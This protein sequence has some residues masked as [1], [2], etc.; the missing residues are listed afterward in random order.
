MILFSQILH[1]TKNGI[2][3][4][5]VLNCLETCMRNYT[6]IQKMDIH[7]S[8]L[9]IAVTTIPRKLNIAPYPYKNKFCI[10]EN[11]KP[12]STQRIML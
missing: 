5:F 6:R 12:I 8:P 7:V 1:K 9:K 11:S 3:F 4:Q 2:Y 10:S